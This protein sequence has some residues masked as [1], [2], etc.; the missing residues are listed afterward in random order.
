MRGWLI[1]P[2]VLILFTACKGKNK[3]PSGVLHPPKMQAVLRDL[4]RAD[5]FLTYFVLNK[6]SSLNKV[7]ESLKYYQQVF[8]I[9]DITQAEFQKSFT[10]YQEHPDHLRI[11]MDSMSRAPVAPPVQVTEPAPAVLAP[12][13]IPDSN[14]QPQ[15]PSRKDTLTRLQKKKALKVE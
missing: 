2:V 13:A 5:Q 9:H 14:Q 7:T 6:D 12:E 4:M 10:F 8:A 3:I 1:I 11:I 15:A